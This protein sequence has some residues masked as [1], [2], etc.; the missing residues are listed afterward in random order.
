MIDDMTELTGD[1]RLI[2]EMAQDIRVLF[3]ESPITRYDPR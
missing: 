2:V 3:C 1:T